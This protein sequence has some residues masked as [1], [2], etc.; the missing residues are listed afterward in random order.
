MPDNPQPRFAGELHDRCN[1]QD[2]SKNFRVRRLFLLFLSPLQIVR[3][4]RYSDAAS[5]SRAPRCMGW[6]GFGKFPVRRST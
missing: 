5:D 3:D 2:T 6:C 1:G 4:S